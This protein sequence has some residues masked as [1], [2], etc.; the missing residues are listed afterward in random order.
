V[1]NILT[2]LQKTFCVDA[3]RIFATGFS[4]GGGMTILLACRL[5]GR[6]AAFAPISGDDYSIPGGCHPGRPVPL[7]DMHGTADPLLLYNGI[8][9]SQNPDWPFPPVQ[10]FLRT[11]ATRDGC[12]G[13]PTIFLQQQRLAGQPGVT[14]MQWTG[15]QGNVLV[16][17]YRIDGGGHQWPPAIA[18]R[19]PA[20]TIWQFFQA[21]ALP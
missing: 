13:G 17:H 20:E 15:C 12:S 18:G 6:I 8:P 16:V 1:S 7:L 4:N 14:G 2:D 21:Y 11:W 10:Q 9:P 3:H 5:A 19:P